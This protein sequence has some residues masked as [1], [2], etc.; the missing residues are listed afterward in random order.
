MALYHFTAKSISLGKGESAVHR[1]AYH[2][3]TQLDDERNAKSTRDYAHKGDLAWSGIFAPKAA[4]D[5]ARDRQQLWNRAEKAERQANGQPARNIEFALPNEL[6]REQQI[7][8]LTDFAREQFARK[9]MIADVCLHSDFDAQGVRRPGVRRDEPRNDHAH[10][11]LTMRRLDGDMFK[12]TKTDAREWNSKDQLAAWREGW[13]K[14]GAKALQKAG[15]ALEAERFAVGHM[16]LP[17][18]RADALKRGDA[19]WADHLDREPD[20]KQGAAVSQME[21]RGQKTD[22]G[23]KRRDIEDRNAERA[24]LLE[25]SR[26][27]ELELERMKRQQADG[28]VQAIFNVA[29]QG[30]AGQG[31][32]ELVRAER[33]AA[34]KVRSVL[35]ERFRAQRVRHEAAYQSRVAETAR[36]REDHQVQRDALYG[37]YA[38]ALDAIWKP[39]AKPKV[40]PDRA[41]WDWVNIV[42][43]ARK[44]VFDDR[45]ASVWGQLVNAVILGR[46]KGVAKLLR[47]AVDPAERRR[48]FEVEQRK[49]TGKLAPRR[50]GRTS[51]PPKAATPE[52]RRV[53]TDRLKAMRAAELSALERT[54]RAGE[55]GLRAR[56]HF[57]RARERDERAL[58]AMEA[59]EAWGRHR[60]VFGDRQKPA[61]PSGRP[62]LAGPAETSKGIDSTARNGPMGEGEGLGVSDGPDDR[63]EAPRGG[64]QGLQGAPGAIGRRSPADRSRIAA[65]RVAAIRAQMERN[66]ADRNRGPEIDR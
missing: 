20:M 22:R 47:L 60:E 53:Q 13:A 23:E 14:A 58:F 3:R 64:H 40:S 7:R 44:S 55:G 32:R 63:P 65:E 42:L 31:R 56:H 16:T 52:P 29:A 50:T 59:K 51:A 15:F 36:L 38:T 19:I 4:P 66:E 33:E 11:M 30:A 45:E 43:T 62:G 57:E 12:K 9:G 17:E 26:V 27:V 2:A 35:N 25:E 5:W 46:G 49:V 34:D 54:F 1:A 8:L 61:A 48:L 39:S 41:A 18:Q 6:T 21:E 24:D 10:M 37:K 28:S